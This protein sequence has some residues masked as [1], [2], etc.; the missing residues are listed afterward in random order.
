VPLEEKYDFSSEKVIGRLVELAEIEN[1]DSSECFEK[2]FSAEAIN[3]G[4]QWQSQLKR[5]DQ[6]SRQ[7]QQS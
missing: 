3:H 7:Q 4:F 2:D 1:S 6:A 5:G